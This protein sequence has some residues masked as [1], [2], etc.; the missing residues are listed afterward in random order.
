MLETKD[1]EIPISSILKNCIALAFLTSEDA[2]LNLNH[3]TLRAKCKKGA[4]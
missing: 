1:Q 3:P 4:L 2:E